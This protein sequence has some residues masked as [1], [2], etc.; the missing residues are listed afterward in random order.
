[1]TILVTGGGRGIGRAIALAFAAP[2]HLVVIAARTRAEVE[3]TAA[4]IRSRG[5][6][7]LALT[8]DVSDEGG[9]ERGFRE[10]R[11]A[12]PGLDVLVNN[13]GIGGG[14]PIH[15]TDH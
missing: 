10:L 8:M 4:D 5:A 13:A 14:E 15:K 9:V 12:S 6:D 1:M 11:S 2:G 3:K 7:A